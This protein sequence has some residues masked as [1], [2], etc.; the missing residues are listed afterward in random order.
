MRPPFG[1]RDFAVIGEA[2]RLGYRVVMWSVPLPDDWEQPG[3]RTI[4]A[5]IVDNV[6]D[7]SIVVLH[8]GNRGIVCGRGRVAARVCD[9]SQE[10]AAT[11]DIV[12]TLRARGFRFVT[13]PELIVD[14]DR[15]PV[16]HTAAR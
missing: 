7:G 2:Q 13:I 11:R 8:D 12:R 16:T 14:A 15:A 10:I 5:R 9:R 3:V 4:A 6:Q 1:A